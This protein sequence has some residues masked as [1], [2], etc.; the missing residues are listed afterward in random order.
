MQDCFKTPQEIENAFDYCKIT[1]NVI[2]PKLAK[3]LNEIV[4]LDLPD[5]FWAIAF[6]YWLFRHICII[7][8][9]YTYLSKIDID[10]TSIK[11]LDK[12][13]FYIPLDHYEYARCFCGDF[14]VQQIVS[15]YH[16]LFSNKKN[17]SMS[18]NFEQVF[19]SNFAPE[20]E[21][22]D[23]TNFSLIQKAFQFRAKFGINFKKIRRK[24]LKKDIPVLTVEPT[25]VLC[26][27][28]STQGVIDELRSKSE[29][30]I[31]LLS[32]PS[33]NINRFIDFNF[34]KKLLEIKSEND[35]EYF[36]VQ[37]LYHCLPQLFLE[38]FRNYYDPYLKDIKNKKFTHIIG[39]YWI[40]YIESSIYI[41][42]AQNEGRKFI[43]YEHG[44]GTVFCKGW[45]EENTMLPYD[46][47]ITTGWGFND[48]KII[49]GGF[50]AR[51]GTPYHFSL[52]K[53][54]I[55][56]LARTNFHYIMEFIVCNATNST[57]IDYL[58]SVQQFYKI[59]PKKLSECF[60]FR[61][62][63]VDFMWDV[64]HMLEI[65]KENIMIDKGD[66]SASIM[67]SKIVI[68]DHLSTGIIEILMRRVP[69]LIIQNEQIGTPIIEEFND[70]FEELKKCGVFHTSS[71]SAV[72]H[73]N[74]IYDDVEGWWNSESVKPVIDKLVEN[75]IAP[76]SKTID[77]LLNLL[78]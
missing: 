73:L 32:L 22:E 71:E 45:L 53:T 47:Y 42:I 31:G 4:E 43:S 15:L 10:K 6:G 3:K 11:L 35:F 21:E 67:N 57:M 66:F 9:K 70:I 30:K 20:I 33:I 76:S 64:E 24:Y 48:K 60:V 36:L 8:D 37:S 41:A 54:N 74:K 52:G 77:Y 58:K 62:R 78:P 51:E 18:L 39:E 1:Y 16:Y 23:K 50:I 56:Y 69:C 25:V 46:G 13:S 75:I 7:Y 19:N 29:G 2:L 63:K 55:L 61:P 40:S 28:C 59:L 17:P 14:G 38:Q 65:K 68:I 12:N 49:K 26:D 27:V 44:G 34:R 72:C 5:K